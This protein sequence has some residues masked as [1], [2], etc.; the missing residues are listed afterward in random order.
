MVPSQ[1]PALILVA[2]AA[3]EDPGSQLPSGA[4]ATE[5]Q[6][7]CI[8]STSTSTDKSIASSSSTAFKY[9]YQPFSDAPARGS[10]HPS[11]EP[12]LAR[13][14][15]RCEHQSC[16]DGCCIICCCGPAR[17]GLLGT[18][19]VPGGTLGN[20][21]ASMLGEVLG[22]TS[23]SQENLRGHDRSRLLETTSTLG[24][25]LGGATPASAPGEALGR[26]TTTSKGCPRGSDG[27]SRE[28]AL[29]RESVSEEPRFPSSS[30]FLEQRPD[31]SSFRQSYRHSAPTKL[32]PSSARHVSHL[33]RT[34]PNFPSSPHV[35]SGD[36]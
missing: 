3:T 7:T 13:T 6:V 28:K 30:F 33:G 31:P 22:R 18:S 16:E 34:S 35:S 21:T 19:S 24:E 32:S 11:D 15:S 27:P 10:M 23:R 9:I 2:S 36:S 4:I 5:D 1:H 12:A 29:A 8:K 26:R 17:E 25:V 14:T 20:T